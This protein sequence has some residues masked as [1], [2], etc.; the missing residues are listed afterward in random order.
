MSLY[1]VTF[2]VCMC[3][4]GGLGGGGLVEGLGGGVVF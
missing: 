4:G 3:G 1:S 2:S